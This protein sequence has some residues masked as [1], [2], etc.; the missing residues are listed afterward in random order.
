[1][2]L[3][4]P[5]RRRF[6]LSLAAVALTLP[7]WGRAQARTT[8]LIVAFPPGGPVDFVARAMAEQLGTELGQQVIVENK[9]GGNGAIAAE[10]VA[11]SAPDATTLWLTSVGAVAIN[12]AL[13]EKLAYDPVRDAAAALGKDPWEWVLG[14]GEDHALVATFPTAKS[15]PKGWTV[16][17]EVLAW[18]GSAGGDEATAGAGTQHRV[19]VAGLP[20]GAYEG[21]GGWRHFSG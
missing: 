7:H 18:A 3:P 19:T 11:R 20:A 13:Y 8:R 10:F 1:M 6:T 2:N 5:S 4:A 12:S 16:V 9:A 21:P 14:G 17:G 15:V